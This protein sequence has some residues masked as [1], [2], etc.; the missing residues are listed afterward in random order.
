MVPKVGVVGHH[1]TGYPPVCNS[2][3]LYWGTQATRMTGALPRRSRYE[4]QLLHHAHGVGHAPA[5]HELTVRDV[6]DGDAGQRYLLARRRDTHEGAGV[7]PPER[8]APHRLVPV[9]KQVVHSGAGA[10]EGG[11]RGSGELL[12]ALSAGRCSRSGVVI[13]PVAGEELVDDP[14]ITFDPKLLR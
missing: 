11:Q 4:P 1:A 7:F 6:V 3:V 12:P 10:G 13:D 8:P 2:T 9:H 5:L 14:H